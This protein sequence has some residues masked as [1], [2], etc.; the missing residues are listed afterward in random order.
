M[1][2]SSE[3]ERDDEP[4]ESPAWD[5]D[6]HID[7]PLE[8]ASGTRTRV[9]D[10]PDC[11]IT[12]NVAENVDAL[13]DALGTHDRAVYHRARSLV[14][15]LPALS[16]PGVADETP[17]VRPLTA[18]AL[19]TRVARAVRCVRWAPPDKAAIATAKLT[20]TE[21]RPELV[22]TTP[23]DRLAL[24]PL[25]AQ[26]NWRSIPYLRGIVECPS[27][28][29]DGSVLQ[30]PGYD[31]ASGY[32]Y[33]PSCEY[34]AIDDS[35][36]QEEAAAAL[37]ELADLFVDFPHVSLAHRMVPVAALLTILARAAIAGPTPCF[38]FDATVRGS[39]KTLQGDV[40]HAIATGRPAPHETLSA[41]EEE[42]EKVL[43]ACAL[44]AA[45][46]VFL[47]NV[48]GLLGGASIEKTLTSE[49]VAFRI[50]G[51]PERVELPWHAVLLVSGNNLQLTD[52][53]I[54][55]CL[56]SRIESPLED[57]TTRTAFTHDLPAAAFTRRPYLLGR[58]L[59]VLRAY[60]S[61]GYPDTGDDPMANP[62]G[63]WS[64]LVARSIRFAGGPN[65]LECRPPAEA[66]AGDE[67]GALRTLLELWD[68]IDPEAAGLTVA[69][70]ARA[71]APRARDSAPDTLDP[72][73]EALDTLA[74]ARGGAADTKALGRALRGS[75]GRWFGDRA[76][77]SAPG[78]AGVAR[79]RRIVR[80]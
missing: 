47:D 72:L 28:R 37:V 56:R 10:R 27:L 71:L 8:H 20:G 22:A 78:H 62:Y 74:P 29:P 42:R 48:K 50:L 18:P 7:P 39:G 76:F 54:R 68:R 66:V 58:A 75:R 11:I 36:T 53:M 44:G 6:D 70:L 34:P 21:A 14:L 40:V 67:L 32:L 51:K 60:I 24:A 45:R 17:V 23:S 73:R 61:H 43:A 69:Q 1:A 64:R 80:H 25:L 31:A 12:G 26:G 77:D 52:D 59:T 38:L 35:P 4:G 57:P 19:L 33:Q 46:V 16:L 65:V 2:S 30:T 49:I 15:A 9:D 41:N 13:D 3:P 5:P 79:W 63:A 55:R